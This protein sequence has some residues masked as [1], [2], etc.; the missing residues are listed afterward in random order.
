MKLLAVVGAGSVLVGLALGWWTTS[1]HWSAKYAGLELA[2]SEASSV[3]V[4][5][6]LEKQQEKLKAAQVVEAK[7]EKAIAEVNLDAVAVVGG[8]GSV[9]R[10]RGELNALRQRTTR[11]LSNAATQRLA[12]RQTIGVLADMLESCS[13]VAGVVAEGFEQARARGLTCEAAYS[14]ALLSSE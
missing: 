14:A 8:D 13:S 1:N 12:D 6:T 9:D 11:D 7:G 5:E 4:T 10:V 2:Q 3:A